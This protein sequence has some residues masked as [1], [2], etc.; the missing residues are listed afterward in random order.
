MKRFLQNLPRL[1]RG[2][3]TSRNVFGGTLEGL[4][5]NDFEDVFTGDENVNT[6]SEPGVP[7]VVQKFVEYLRQDV[8]LDREGIFRLAGSA[9][10][11]LQM[12]DEIERTNV[13]DFSGTG[14]REIPSICGLFKSFLRDLSDG[15]IP[16]KCFQAFADAG[17][18]ISKIKQAVAQIPQPNLDVLFYICKYL[19]L[20]ADREHKNKMGIPNLVIVFAPNLFRCPTEKGNAEKF[21]VESLQA[22]KVFTIMLN[23]LYDIFDDEVLNGNHSGRASPTKSKLIKYSSMKRNSP[24]SSGDI[25]NIGGSKGQLNYTGSMNGSSSSDNAGKNERASHYAESSPSLHNS[26]H[27]FADSPTGASRDKESIDHRISPRK[28]DGVVDV[29]DQRPSLGATTSHKQDTKALPMLSEPESKLGEKQPEKD[30]FLNEVLA[31]I[32]RIQNDGPESASGSTQSL[33]SRP[34]TQQYQTATGESS[35]IP[36]PVRRQPE[37]DYEDVH[38]LQRVGSQTNQAPHRSRSASP[39]SPHAHIQQQTSGTKGHVDTLPP[40]KRAANLRAGSFPGAH[41]RTDSILHNGA[42]DGSDQTRRR[43][44]LSGSNNSLGDRL[45]NGERRT[46]TFVEPTSESEV[47]TYCTTVTST[48]ADESSS[49]AI[50]MHGATVSSTIANA[51]RPLPVL[52]NPGTGHAIESDHEASDLDATSTGDDLM[53]S[54]DDELDHDDYTTNELDMMTGKSS[55]LYTAATTNSRLPP[56]GLAN[57][58]SNQLSPESPSALQNAV[59][60]QKS[61]NAVITGDIEKIPLGQGRVM[62]AAHRITRSMESLNDSQAIKKGSNSSLSKIKSPTPPLT[63]V[64]NQVPSPVSSNYKRYSG[65]GESTAAPA[66]SGEKPSVAS[67]LFKLRPPWQLSREGPMD[68]PHD[69]PLEYNDETSDDQTRASI[70]TNVNGSLS[71]RVANSDSRTSAASKPPLPAPSLLTMDGYKKLRAEGKALAHKIREG[72]EAGLKSAQMSDD[73]KRFRELKAYLQDHPPITLQ[74]A[75]SELLHSEHGDELDAASPQGSTTSVSACQLAVQ[76]LERQRKRDGRP[77]DVMTMSPAHLNDEKTAVRKELGALKS[78][79][80]SKDEAVKQI[81]TKE[82]RQMMR[83]LYQ[84][85]CEVKDRLASVDPLACPNEGE[86][87]EDQKMYKQLRADKR[88][89]QIMLHNF[90]EQFKKENGRNIQTSVDRE[91]VAAEYKR[92]KE[93]KEH[94]KDIEE[95]QGITAASDDTSAAAS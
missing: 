14:E 55:N 25:F 10:L 73:I 16:R 57:T 26:P 15:V 4:L 39:S 34:Q 75:P 24:L 21:L 6:G 1:G 12:R 50:Q 92:Y 35:A 84:R 64:N 40:P 36:M 70:T 13:I 29:S 67:R 5:D 23:N 2:L 45:S 95:R 3:D 80:A 53:D 79:F 43:S 86:E 37:S 90:Q 69:R 32:E 56:K 17:D 85:Y 76:K 93:I 77:F 89:L 91:P 94:I 31:S 59:V 9:A 20:V 63:N 65:P 54:T 38:R 22:T 87:T 19:L 52:D 81:P 47:D 41:A 66:G 82:D 61:M 48:I 28:S 83:D 58:L 49:H 88:Q 30:S 8:V 11:I 46:V 27:S 72:K 71:R 68:S 74:V 18:S 33:S 78:V 42:I 44:S 62:E 7:S 60:F 51:K